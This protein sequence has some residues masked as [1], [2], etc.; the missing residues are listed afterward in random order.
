MSDSKPGR[1]KKDAAADTYCSDALIYFWR[2]LYRQYGTRAFKVI[3]A[4]GITDEDLE[5]TQDLLKRLQVL[6]V[7]TAPGRRGENGYMAVWQLVKV[8]V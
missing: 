3:D 8:P 6:N 5:I 4:C 2:R 7:A 1:P